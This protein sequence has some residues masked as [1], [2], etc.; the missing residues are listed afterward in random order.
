[1]PLLKR[2]IFFALAVAFS[3]SH[4]QW[5]ATELDGFAARGID[6]K[7]I[8]HVVNYTLPRTRE[9]YVHRVGRTGRGGET[10]KAY[11]FV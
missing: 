10:G 9:D 3:A 5:T 4:A 7:N 6:V 11:S 1:M 8:S 2:G